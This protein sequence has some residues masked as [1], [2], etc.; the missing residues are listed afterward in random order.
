MNKI[1]TI[2]A[3]VGLL[4]VAIGLTWWL[5]DRYAQ[6]QIEYVRESYQTR[7]DSVSSVTRAARA[8]R[9]AI[10]DSLEA[11]SS[12]FADYVSR[13]EDQIASYSQLVGRLRI[14]RDSL[15]AASDSLARGLALARLMRPAG[16]A[17]GMFRDT[18][19]TRRQ[20]WGDSLFATQ[21]RAWI[22]SDSL[23]VEADLE[24]LRPVRLDVATTI[25]EDSRRVNYFAHSPDF[26][27]LQVRT[28]TEL[29]PPK[30]TPWGWIAA[31]ALI[32]REAVKIIF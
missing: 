24:Q 30:K 9:G 18:T 11:V 21:A 17:E 28:V 26:D 23:G 25:S 31:G 4:A 2:M 10:E 15:A 1:K 5:T 6:S 29:T 19:I 13:S 7:L 14:A 12:E 3:V 27:S 16:D 20:T 22:R 8:R 32:V